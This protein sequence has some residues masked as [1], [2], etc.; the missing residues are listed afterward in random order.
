MTFGKVV[1]SPKIQS[2]RYQPLPSATSSIQ[3]HPRHRTLL[4]ILQELQ[5]HRALFLRGLL[6]Q[7]GL[8][9]LQPLRLVRAVRALVLG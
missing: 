6:G 8:S 2:P 9:H 7:H 4:Q 3:A 5:D 1:E